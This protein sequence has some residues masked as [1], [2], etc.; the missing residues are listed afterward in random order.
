MPDPTPDGDVTLSAGDGLDLSPDESPIDAAG[1]GL[2][3]EPG[4]APALET[5]AP[6]DDGAVQ[7]PGEA[8]CLVA[9]EASVHLA[10]AD[11]DADDDESQVL[12]EM[13]AYSGQV[14]KNHWW[15][16]DFVLDCAGMSFVGSQ[17]PVL[18]EHVRDRIV[19]MAPTKEIEHE[20]RLLVRG[21]V[22]T[23][24]A[25]GEEVARLSKAKFP[26]QASMYFQP[27]GEVVRLGDGETLQINGR[28]VRGPLLVFPRTRI[29]EVSFCV[30]GADHRTRARAWAAADAPAV[31]VRVKPLTKESDPMAAPQNPQAGADP[32]PAPQP[33]LSKLTAEQLKAARPDLAKALATEPPATPKQLREALPGADDAFIL[34]QVEAEASV[35]AARL[36]WADKVSNDHAAA[37]HLSA[38]G[39]PAVPTAASDEAEDEDAPK[40]LR[41]A[42]ARIQKERADEGRPV[43]R[44][45][46][47]SLVDDRWPDLRRKALADAN[48]KK[49]GEVEAH[50]AMAEANE[51]DAARQSHAG[52]G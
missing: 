6:G 42:V 39:G 18:R 47:M 45:R 29:R 25:D 12:F 20:T 14:I 43:T 1:L 48:P 26:W 16:G 10:E 28:T 21:R 4:E 32:A 3:L 8:L 13:T 33:D 7:V 34:A 51:T 44:S 2:G 31:P 9:G 30:L 19:G 36:A 49:T 27:L 52:G 35:T 15:W 37:S 24:T 23:T 22:L 17:M 11:P 41:E 5:A 40:S 50:F 38:T 46:A